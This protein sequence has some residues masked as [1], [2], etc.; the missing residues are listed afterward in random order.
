MSAGNC[1]QLDAAD[2]QIMVAVTGCRSV[3]HYRRRSENPMTVADRSRSN[4]AASLLAGAYPPV[5]PPGRKRRRS[6]NLR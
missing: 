1:I 6:R 5:P 2:R 3:S 4:P